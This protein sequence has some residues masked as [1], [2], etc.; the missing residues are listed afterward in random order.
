[1]KF[2]VWNCNGSA[3]YEFL[4]TTKEV[5]KRYRLYLVGL[6]ETKIS[7]LIADQ[8]CRKLGLDS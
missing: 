7:G 3:S 2:L 6:V 5:V 1:M 8:V 4:C